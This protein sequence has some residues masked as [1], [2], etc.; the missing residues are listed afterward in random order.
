LTL[1]AEIRAYEDALTHA[2]ERKRPKVGAPD[3]LNLSPEWIAILRRLA[4]F[5]SFNSGDVERAARELG[6]KQTAVN[7]RS[8]LS[9]YTEKGIIRRLGLGKYRVSDGVKLTLETEK[10]TMIPVGKTIEGGSP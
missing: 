8:Q 2:R 5:T 7:V 6:F 10:D 9:A 3:G 4:D 1:L